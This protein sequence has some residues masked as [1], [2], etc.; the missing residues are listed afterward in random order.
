V[1]DDLADFPHGLGDDRHPRPQ[2][3]QQFDRAL[4][5]VDERVV[6]GIDR[7]GSLSEDLR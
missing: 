5:A 7:Q 4:G 3:I 1:A 6:K 2:Q